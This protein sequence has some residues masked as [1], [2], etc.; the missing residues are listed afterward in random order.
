[1]FKNYLTKDY[2]WKKPQT[3]AHD[4]LL[5]T[6]FNKTKKIELPNNLRILDSGCGGGHIMNNFFKMGFENIWGFDIAESG[7]NVAR[8]NFPE[9]GD[10]LA[11]HSVYD[12]NLP[13]SLAF[14]EYDLVLSI[15]VI[16]HLYS[17]ETYIKNIREWLKTGGYVILTTP[18]HGYLKN[19]AIA[20]TNKFDKH[21]TVQWEGGHIKFFSKT[22]LTQLF[23]ECGFSVLEFKGCG[24]APYLWKSMLMVAQK[25]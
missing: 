7:I 9:L 13:N 11:I 2:G 20:L 24:R 6:I 4:Y 23:K 8:S 18:Y 16:E 10:R 17:P 15:E 19:L 5:P 14:K 21:M 3:C 25:K 1:M 22:T 12:K